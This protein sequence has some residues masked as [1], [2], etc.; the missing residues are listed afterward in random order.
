MVEYPVPK[1]VSADDVKNILKGYYL[2]GAHNEPVKTDEVENTI[3][4][5]DRVGR[6]TEFLVD[7]GLL[8]THGHQRGL[9]SGGESIAESLV[10]GSSDLARKLMRESLADW[11]FTD[12]IT[13]FIDMQGG[14]IPGDEL[15]DYISANATTS[16][17]QGIRALIDLL[18]WSDVLSEDNQGKYFLSDGSEIPVEDEAETPEVEDVGEPSDMVTVDEGETRTSETPGSANIQINLEFSGQ[19]SP[20]HIEKIIHSIRKALD[21]PLEDIELAEIS[22]EDDEISD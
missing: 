18:V 21:T 1:R 19:D 2:E 4:L 20:S 14:S 8:E 13:G 11:E 9:T 15:I 12:K 3:Q 7:I 6:Q 22:D 17:K 5:V 16:N 10:G